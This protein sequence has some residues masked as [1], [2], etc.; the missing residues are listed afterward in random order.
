MTRSIPTC[1]G[2][3]QPSWRCASLAS[4]YPHV[5]GAA[6]AVGTEVVYRYG[7]SPRVWGSLLILGA[8]YYPDGSIPTCVGQPKSKGMPTTF[9]SV[10]PHVC[11][12]ATIVLTAASGCIGLSPRVWGSRFLTRAGW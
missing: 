11:G 10:Y 1:V 4:V 12:A 2:Q 3:P 7:L 6:A 8:K 5:C 9:S